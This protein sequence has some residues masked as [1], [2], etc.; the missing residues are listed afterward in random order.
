MTERLIDPAWCQTETPDYD[1][2]GPDCS[3]C[4]LPL[5]ADKAE[6]DIC[7]SCYEAEEGVRPDEHLEAAYA[8]ANGDIE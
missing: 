4:G 6:F 1:E 7:T 2:D 8:E 3:V 5:D